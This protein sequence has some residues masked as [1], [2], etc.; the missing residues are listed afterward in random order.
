MSES[1]G[2]RGRTDV[3]KLHRGN[4]SFKLVERS[5]EFLAARKF[6]QPTQHIRHRVLESGTGA[7]VLRREPFLQLGRGGDA[8]RGGQ[9][10]TAVHELGDVLERAAAGVVE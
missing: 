5:V 7:L 10:G 6:P 3:D 4:F 8:L 2:A 9:T 1:A